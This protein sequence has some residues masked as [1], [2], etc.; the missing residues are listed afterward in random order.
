MERYSNKQ[1]EGRKRE[2]EG[3]RGRVDLRRFKDL[4]SLS[5]D[6]PCDFREG[7]GLRPPELPYW[8]DKNQ[9]RRGSR[10]S[11]PST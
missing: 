5:A 6:I 7:L 9:T 11:S 4:R 8:L 10:I 3:D 2:I 1:V